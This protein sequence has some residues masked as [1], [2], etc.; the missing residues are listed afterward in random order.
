MA[1]TKVTLSIRC[2]QLHEMKFIGDYTLENER[3]VGIFLLSGHS[4]QQEKQFTIN[5][6]SNASGSSLYSN[7]SMFPVDES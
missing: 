3:N 4:T 2:H 5:Y 6:D 7:Y 1:F